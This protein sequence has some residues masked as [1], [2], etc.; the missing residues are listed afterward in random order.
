MPSADET[1]LAEAEPRR[2]RPGQPPG[3][4]GGGAPAPFDLV[5]A[6]EQVVARAGH[7]RRNLIVTTADLV[8]VH[9]DAGAL[10]A[11]EAVDAELRRAFG[12][13]ARGLAG[14]SVLRI[15][16][17]PTQLQ[18]M[19]ADGR[20][21]PREIEWTFGRVVWKATL[22]AVWRPDGGLAGFAIA[23]IDESPAHRARAVLE[24][25]R[26]ESEDLPVPV[27]FPDA[28]ME[29]WFGNAACE[30][31]LERLAPHLA[32]PVNP[33]EGVPIQLFL[34]DEA[35]RAALFADPRK[36]PFKRQ[37]RIG[38]ETVSFLIAA[39][40]DGSQQYLG[41]Q[42]TWEIVH[43]TRQAEAGGGRPEEVAPPS[44]QPEAAVP[45]AAVPPAAVPQAAAPQESPA[46]R[47]RA[48]A[49][50]LEAAG[51]EL[52]LLTRLLLA[53]ADDA[54]G[55]VHVTVT[56]PDRLAEAALRNHDET[57][58]VAA[59]ALAVLE[60]ARQ[61]SGTHTRREETERALATLNGIA[62]RANRLALDGALLA[63]Q[64]GTSEQTSGLVDETQRF[65]RALVEQV[66][67]L[68]TRAQASA[69]VLRQSAAAAARLAGLR[70]QLAEGAEGEP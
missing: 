62:R 30:H 69:D 47:L 39:V 11:T 22:H 10:A 56:P 15:H 13:G 34:P 7:D 42:M 60:A 35:E 23:W 41:P 29:R 12:R 32:R 19:L 52:M 54:E 17:A 8:I 25:L 6:A 4:G 16:P 61:V 66:R 2:E 51:Q 59:A 1:T 40:L 26:A 18:A 70:A 53:V 38:P 5:A 14:Q 57:A 28:T 45:Q 48:Q 36:L 24:R 55:Q 37:I 21:L 68:T 9:L 20:A 49:R 27:M 65:S 43:F 44:P 58:T 50:S 3:F 46:T 64:D 67:A 63:V 31:A 33:L